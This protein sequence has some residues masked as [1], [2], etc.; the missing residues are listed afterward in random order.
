[1]TYDMINN[2]KMKG[3]IQYFSDT[4]YYCIPTQYKSLK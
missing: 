4:I 1:M 3:N 2:I